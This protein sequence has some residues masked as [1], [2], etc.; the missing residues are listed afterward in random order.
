M[1]RSHDSEFSSSAAM[2]SAVASLIWLLCLLRV[3]VG[4]GK[5]PSAYGSNAIEKLQYLRAK[6]D[7]M[8]KVPVLEFGEVVGS[9]IE[10]LDSNEGQDEVVSN[11]DVD[12]LYTVYTERLCRLYCQRF[13]KR[14]DV[15]APGEEPSLQKLGMLRADAMSECEKAMS[16]G[17]PLSRINL[18]DFKP[19]LRDLE[20]DIDKVIKQIDLEVNI[21]NEGASLNAREGNYKNNEGNESILLKILNPKI[22]V[23]GSGFVADFLGSKSRKRLKWVFMQSLVLLFNYVQNEITRRTAIR[24]IEKKLAEIPEFPSL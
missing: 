17:R 24:T 3:D 9:L 7:E 5:L 22:R 2:A 8:D 19:A 18:W 21:D 16:G 1:I 23:P 20:L 4:Q 15:L 10:D 13:I 12:I 14:L 11:F 6:V